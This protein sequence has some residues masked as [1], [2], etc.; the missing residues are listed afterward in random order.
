[1]P[2]PDEVW[3]ARV[4]TE[5]L[6]E[7]N[8]SDADVDKFHGSDKSQILNNAIFGRSLVATPRDPEVVVNAEA[9]PAI[10]PSQPA[11]PLAPLAPPASTP[12]AMDT[13]PPPE[14]TA[15]IS[16]T[17]RRDACVRIQR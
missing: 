14:P 8:A 11:A 15:Q 12:A 16:T 7:E 5:V 17:S 1:M 10:V 3:S 9:S 13:Q 6:G 2:T 4:K